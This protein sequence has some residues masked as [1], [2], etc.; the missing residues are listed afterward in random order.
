MR[1]FAD[2]TS[3]T[4]MFEAEGCDDYTKVVNDG[5]SGGSYRQEWYADGQLDVYRP[6]HNLQGWNQKSTGPGNLVQIA[7]GFY[8]A[9]AVA[10]DGKVWAQPIAGAPNT[11]TRV[12]NAPVLT[13]ISVGKEYVWGLN[14]TTVYSTKI[15]YG[16]S[17]WA[18]TGW[19]PRTG[20]MVQL[21]A[22]TTEV[23]GVNASGQV[24][25]RSANG[26]G[27]WTQVAGTMDKVFAGDEFVWGIQGS[28]IYYTRSS[29]ISWTAVTN[30]NNLTNL[31][32]GSEE[33][34]G[35]NATGQVYRRSVSGIGGWDAVSAPTGVLSS[36][37]VGEGYAWGL[38]GG[39]P[40]S[41]RLEGFQGSTALP[42][43]IPRVVAGNGQISVNW[44]AVTGATGYHV[45]RATSSG[46]G[47]TTIASNVLPIA[48]TLNYTD[49]AVTS[50]TTYYY[51]ISA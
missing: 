28:N 21:S 32:V 49:A 50:G 16:W 14:G 26:T 6:L 7:A 47:Y 9:W 27:D 24:F 10:S 23:W 33:V 5:N 41:R 18:S 35:S 17:Y 38:V 48:N 15:P 25:R 40:S 39:T 19:T 4:L 8:D 1:E 46:G 43:L 34:W 36:L 22:G 45:K 11:W 51:V 3:Q 2:P 29:S 13:S 20:S 42:P 30:P 37:A 44:T 12:T 31:A